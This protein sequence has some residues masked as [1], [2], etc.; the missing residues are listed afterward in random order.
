MESTPHTTS[1]K[2]LIDELFS[3]SP[4]WCRLHIL[5]CWAK[6]FSTQRDPNCSK[7]VELIEDIT[8]L[9]FHH[10]LTMNQKNL[11]SLVHLPFSSQLAHLDL[12]ASNIGNHPTLV[13][14]L[15]HPI[16]QHLV[17]LNL[18]GTQLQTLDPLFPSPA[19]NFPNLH[20]LNLSYNSSIDVSTPIN[21]N[22]FPQLKVLNLRRSGGPTTTLLN[23]LQP[24]APT[25]TPPPTSSPVAGP[26]GSN[27]PNKDDQL[28]PNQY[29]GFRLEQLSVSIQRQHLHQHPLL[30]Q[31]L[32]SPSLPQ[33]T[34]LYISDRQINQSVI[35]F[36]F[37]ADTG[38]LKNLTHLDLS[39]CLLDHNALR[40]LAQSAP[41]LSN[42][43]TLKLY[44]ALLSHHQ[45][46]YHLP[47]NPPLPPP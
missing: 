30:P 14:F 35:K 33:L 8:T 44:G 7:V 28:P 31:L 16:F 2:G 34:H 40:A 47:L 5:F 6:L 24:P 12:S 23:I 1:A 18:S 43:T 17:T 10:Y 13:N 37:G 42:L 4:S 27:P 38:L 25:P 36:L 15:S 3:Q 39:S 46:N 41:Y 22:K 19:H 45:N 32:S 9:N 21:P 26:N 20:T 11:L 29:Q